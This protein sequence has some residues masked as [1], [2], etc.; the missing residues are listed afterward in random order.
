M[1]FE[2]GNGTHRGSAGDGTQSGRVGNRQ[3]ASVDQR[4]AVIT[5]TTGKEQ[6]ADVGLGQRGRGAGDGAG[7]CDIARPRE[8]ERTRA[9]GNGRGAAEGECAEVRLDRRVGIQRHRT[10]EGVGA[11]KVAQGAIGGRTRAG[12][13]EGFGSDGD[14]VLEFKR[15]VRAHSGA[16]DEGAQR[17]RVGNRQD[18]G[19]DRRRAVIPIATRKRG[20]SRPRLGERTRTRDDV[21]E[22]GCVAT[23]KR[24]RCVIGDRDR[25]ERTGGRTRAHLDRARGN[26][27]DA[28]EGIRA[29]DGER[30]RTAAGGLGETR[31]VVDLTD[32]AKRAVTQAERAGSA[33]DR[34]RRAAD[35]EAAQVQRTSVEVEG[36]DL[37][38][39]S[40]R[41][42]DVAS[43][44]QHAA[45]GDIERAGGGRGR[46]GSTR[47]AEVGDIDRTARD[48]KGR[49]TG[50]A[51]ASV[52][53]AVRV[54]IQR[55]DRDRAS[56]DVSG[57]LDRSDRLGSSG[58]ANGITT[59]RHSADGDRTAADIEGRDCCAIGR[60]RRAGILAHQ[61]GA[62]D[63]DRAG[64]AGSHQV[65]R[66]GVR[67]AELVGP[68]TGTQV[69]IRGD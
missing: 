51:P 4:R 12:E 61:Q 10:A 48:I 67:V 17:G 29:V 52:G 64:S 7:D 3:D 1:E 46:I 5:I 40:V 19:I 15:S 38:A 2:R 41:V 65:E 54:H 16:S 14:I 50:V 58:A 13:T 22:G 9:S 47:Q 20:R 49:E 69:Y 35:V 44:R 33:T 25:T 27:E 28:R 36:D 18:A 53:R 30:V 66:S 24:Q 32:I 60:R 63:G 23:V 45:T 68:R 59:H 56:A 39:G 55:G 57:R 42:K 21:R 26:R 37:D 6:R 8:G 11:R 34:D 43:H 31:P 62:A